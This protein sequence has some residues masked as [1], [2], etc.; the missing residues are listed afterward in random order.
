MTIALSATGVGAYR[1]RIVDEV[2]ALYEAAFPDK[3]SGKFSVHD[4]RRCR[5]A[6]AHV[7]GPDVLDVGVG[8]GQTFNILAR[9]PAIERL[10]GVDIKWNKKLL[11]PERGTLETASIF[12]LPFED[13]SFDCVLCME[14][15]EHLEVIEFPKAL[16]ELR[17]VCR[18]A[19]IMTVPYEEPEPLWHHDRRGGH[20]QQFSEEKIERWFPRAER[21]MVLRGKSGVP[22]IMLVERGVPR[23][24]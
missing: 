11:R 21:Q 7:V 17:R 22:W 4:W 2:R 18:G 8:A 1:D 14:V 20:R 3:A 9:D 19:L 23:E 6:L 16:H 5:D 15:L 24:P 12:R 13:R 10:V